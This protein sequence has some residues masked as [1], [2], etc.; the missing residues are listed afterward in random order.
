MEDPKAY[1]ERLKKQ[2][3]RFTVTLDEFRIRKEIGV[4]GFGRVYLAKRKSDG[5]EVAIK[6]WIIEQ[7]TGR[8]LLYFCREIEIFSKNDHPFLLPF[9]GFT[10]TP[11][12]SII[13]EFMPNGSL[14]DLIM[15]NSLTPSQKNAIA[16]A[17]AAGMARLH[18]QNIIHRDLKPMNVLMDQ[19][20]FPKI[21]DFGVSR[22]LEDFESSMITHKIGTPAWM[23]PELFGSSDYTNK[24]DVYSYAIILWQ[25][26]TGKLPFRGMNPAKIMET[27]Y[28]KQERPPLPPL[29]SLSIKKLIQLCWSQEPSDRPSFATIYEW[30][31]SGRVMFK[32]AQFDQT[33]KIVEIVNEW[34]AKQ[35]PVQPVHQNLSL[36]VQKLFLS[37][38]QL[39]IMKFTSTLNG[40]NCKLF[41]EALPKILA[42]SSSIDAIR[43]A[44]FELLKLISSNQECLQI[45]LSTSDVYNLPFE[46]ENFAT[47]ALSVLIPI[48]EHYPNIANANLVKKLDSLVNR[49]PL[50]IIRLF[51]ILCDSF[52]DTHVDWTVVDSLIIRADVFIANHEAKPLLHALFKLI[53]KNGPVREGR[54]KYIMAIFDK[55]AQLE[56]PESILAVYT[57]LIAMRLP[58]IT[59]PSHTILLHLKSANAS[60]SLAAIQLL[61]FSKPEVITKELLECV[62][63]G[64]VG[65]KWAKIAILT[66]SNDIVSARLLLSMTN[67]WLSPDSRIDETLQLQIILVL[68][69]TPENRSLIAE[70]D[71]IPI[72]F[73]RIIQTQ[74]IEYFDT[75]YSAIK[76][77]P[78]TAQFLTKLST[79]HFISDYLS[80]I[81]KLNIEQLYVKGYLLLDYLCRRGYFPESLMLLDAAVKHI[82]EFPNLQNFAIAYLAVISNYPAGAEELSKRHLPELINQVALNSQ[83]EVYSNAI[84]SNVTNHN[85][86]YNP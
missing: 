38:N 40:K 66:L 32:E 47:I 46:N 17:I 41:Y 54:F 44:L 7:L 59:L 31:A 60:I 34:K 25:M 6:E 77:L 72:F 57:S 5:K 37:N 67:F 71:D 64:S 74:K 14:H 12:Y 23:A 85:N 73:D 18:E 49:Y 81:I 75:L 68:L 9:I 86:T 24:A 55:C 48:F 22:I 28:A 10:A 36:D 65:S 1:F 76:R 43:T 50:K 83:L 16:T 58:V 62:L 63:R 2:L 35:L 8:K 52:N 19:N 61:C 78:I 53:M 30:F 84:T 79:S 21:C 20:F 39:E 51:S 4:G 26:E 13:T 82:Q 42:N 33:K 3:L 69:I 15:K 11:P 80:L 27:I 56:D 45:Y 29:A 70:N